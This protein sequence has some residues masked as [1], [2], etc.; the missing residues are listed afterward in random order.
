MCF[1]YL[2]QAEDKQASEVRESVVFILFIAFILF[3]SYYFIPLVMFFG[4]YLEIP[5]GQTMNYSISVS[6]NTF[7]MQRQRNPIE[8]SIGISQRF[9]LVS[10]LESNV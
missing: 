4:L 2:L 10:Y 9:P 7:E 3:G 1:V 5:G 8:I 6:F